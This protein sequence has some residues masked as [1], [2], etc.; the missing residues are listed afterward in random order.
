MLL[1]DRHDRRAAGSLAAAGA[2][3]GAAA[4]LLVRIAPDVA[5]RPL[6]GDEALAGLI[7]A[8]PLQDLFRIVMWERGG[9][10][11]HFVLAHVT[12]RLDASLEALRWLS[13][14]FALATIPLCYDLGRRL[15][16]RVA[17]A[18]A[19]IVVAT[20]ST[21]A[22]SGAFGRMYTLFAFAGALAADLFVRALELRTPRSVYAAAAAAWLLP[23][24][25]P[26]GAAPVA[27]MALVALALWRGRPLLPAL[28]V[29]ALALALL[30]FAWADLQFGRRF[31]VR[32]STGGVVEPSQAGHFLLSSLEG[33]AGFSGWT[34]VVLLALAL[35][36]GVLLARRSPAIAVF[37]LVSIGIPPLALLLVAADSHPS[38][39]AR[40]MIY[41]LPIWAALIGVAVARAVENRAAA[42]RVAAV[43]AVAAVAA[44][45]E[46]GEANESRD[47]SAMPYALAEPAAW[48]EERVRERDALFPYSP[49]YFEAL[50][51]ATRGTIFLSRGP[52]VPTE[53]AL[54]RV[55]FPVRR[56]YVAVLARSSTVDIGELATRLGQGFEARRFGS[57][58]LV[59]ARGP[60]PDGVSLVAAALVAVG[61]VRTTATW[62]STPLRNDLGLSI[63]TL[64]RALRDLDRT[65]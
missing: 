35:A 22:I 30:P 64:C 59:E 17:G 49:V 60:F 39:S 15:A 2:V 14:V 48:L 3:A 32:G 36:G 62:A 6:A 52:G 47:P 61:T 11:L 24:I 5:G 28:P 29:I 16:G 25:H 34:F 55:D 42:A 56:L 37:A 57:W 10:P 51:A 46:P 65:C 4:F 18:S 50:T 20:S 26:Y 54:E 43:V 53:R 38:L 23:A 63:G 7:A 31:E 45:S 40:H 19:A 1:H 9:A 33:Y 44:L 12:L 8:E 27:A 21:L 58:I 41:G 13:V